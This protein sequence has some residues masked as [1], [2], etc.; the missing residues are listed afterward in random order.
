MTIEIL[1]SILGWATVIN[2]SLITVW[3][4][5]FM[6]Y[7]DALFRLHSKWFKL[8]EER[9]DTIHYTGMAFYKIGTYLFNFVPFLAIQ[10]VT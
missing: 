7:H 3:F 1:S 5:V 8:P 9:F 10:I 4:L 6:F 2:L